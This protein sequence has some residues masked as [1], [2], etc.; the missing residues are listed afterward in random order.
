MKEGEE[1]KRGKYGYL[2]IPMK[3]IKSFLSVNIFF[4][5]N[6]K[7]KHVPFSTKTVFSAYDGM[8]FRLQEGLLNLEHLMLVK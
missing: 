7:E 3:Y 2:R 4:L 8:L 5:Q 1:E 6:Y